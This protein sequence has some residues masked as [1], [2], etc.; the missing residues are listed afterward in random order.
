MEQSPLFEIGLPIALFLI[1]IGMG[2]T[3]TVRDFRE[4][5]VAPKATLFGCVAQ[6]ILLPLIAFV[7]ATALALPP[8]L[9][10][11]LVL[12]AACP[13]GTTSNLFAFIGRGDVAL[14]IVLTVIASLLTIISLPLFVN[15]AMNVYYD[16][17]VALQLPVLRTVIT[18]F[19]I[20]LVPVGIGMLVRRYQPGLAARAERIVAIFGL[21]VLI[22]VIIA[23][24]VSVGDQA[25]RLLNAAGVA[26][27]LLN[28]AGI[29]LG[30]GGGLLMGL[31]R[32]QAFTLA[33]ELGIK[34]GTLGLMIALSLMDSP[35]MSI[36][37]AVYGLLM[38][39]FGFLLLGYSRL[40]GIGRP[41]KTA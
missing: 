9:A 22:G 18:L 28:I 36:P 12:I 40:T 16:D 15:W 38:F 32:P 19:V 29:V 13:G 14:S 17:G 5:V 27:V 41:E 35:E 25:L 1:M 39:I 3:L 30:M 7:I 23:I 31:S 11:G 33:V 21:V 2:L 8:A 34:N 20:I 10:V 37:A 6:I 4:V 24:L 26:A